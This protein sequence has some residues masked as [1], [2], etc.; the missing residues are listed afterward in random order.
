VTRG[1]T[2]LTTAPRGPGG[3][4]TSGADPWADSM[5]GARGDLGHVVDEDDPELAEAVDHDLVVDDLVVAVDGRLEDPHHPG[6]GLDGHL[7]AG[8][9]APRRGQQ[10]PFD[11]HGT[12][13]GLPGGCGATA[14]S[15]GRGWRLAPAGTSIL[16]KAMSL[17]RVVAVAPGSPQPGPASCP[18]TRSSP[19][20]ASSPETS[21]STSCWP[22]RPSWSWRCA[23]GGLELSVQVEREGGEPLGMEV[24]AA[25][26]DRVRT[27]D[28]HC[29]FCFIHQLPK[30]MRKSLYVKDDD[31]RLSFLYGNFT[32]LTRFTEA[33]LERVLTEG[34]RRCSCRST[35]PTPRCGP[36]CCATAGAPPACAGCGRCSTA[37]S[38]CTARSWSARG[39][40]RR[41]PGGHAGRVLD[42]Y[43]ELA[44]VACV[45]LGVSRFNH[46]AGHAAP[47]RRPR[48]LSWSTW[49]RS[50]RRSSSPA[51]GPPARVRRRRVLPAGRAARSRRWRPTGRS[52]STT[53][54]SAWPGPSRPPSRGGTSGKILGKRGRVDFSARSRGLRLLATG[55]HALQVR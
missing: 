19:W 21:S 54:A 10:H 38:R 30:G 50:G 41:R 5:S 27:C 48:P 51:L 28:N 36:A 15:G 18:A 6:E 14:G 55:H 39:Q 40:R 2:A 35:P 42:E 13:S 11:F 43:P 26:F 20:T 4:T 32:T 37:A 3:A 16:V 34:C 44:S 31:Y 24:D 47:H 49:W 9:E 53:T 8:A 45:P 1:Q 12:R 23:A 22:T 17:P 29:E 46:E 52:P 7:H 33:D 25:L